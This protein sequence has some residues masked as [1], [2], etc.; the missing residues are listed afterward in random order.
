LRLHKREYSNFSEFC[1][2]KSGRRYTNYV[3]AGA[4]AV[5]NLP[6]KVST[7]VLTLGA[8]RKLAKVL[9]TQCVGLLQVVAD[10]G[11]PVTATAIKRPLRG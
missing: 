4:E 5:N 7:I 10:V 11:K 1:Q 8:A 9:P 6:E 3:I 2:K